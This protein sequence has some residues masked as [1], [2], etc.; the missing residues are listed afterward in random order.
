MN[1]SVI[2]HPSQDL[3]V[4]IPQDMAIP[5]MDGL[6]NFL[7]ISVAQGDASEST[8]KAVLQ[9]SDQ[10]RVSSKRF[11][12]GVRRLAR[13]LRLPRNLTQTDPSR[14]KNPWTN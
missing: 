10:E 3:D 8:I 5:L 7:R 14:R 9:D 13:K 4:A 11:L 6:A 12:A 1:T 2:P